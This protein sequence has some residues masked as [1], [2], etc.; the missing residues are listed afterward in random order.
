MVSSSGQL[1]SEVAAGNTSNLAD[2]VMEWQALQEVSPPFR[3]ADHLTWLRV[4][5]RDSDPRLL[6]TVADRPG[7][8]VRP[9]SYRGAWGAQDGGGA[10]EHEPG[11]AERQASSDYFVP[12]VPLEPFLRKKRYMEDNPARAES[13]TVQRKEPQGRRVRRVQRDGVTDERIISPFALTGDL[14]TRM[15]ETWEARRRRVQSKGRG[16]EAVW[17]AARGSTGCERM[18]L[19]V[20]GVVFQIDG[21]N[22]WGIARVWANVLPAVRIAVRCNRR[23]KSSGS[24]VV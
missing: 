5:G 19:V 8:G 24:V 17:G 13:Q 1:I 18:H 2:A 6:T 4:R 21:A 9:S 10:G 14:N 15:K 22:P 11:H 20:D 23:S 7:S 16:G 12:V 3:L